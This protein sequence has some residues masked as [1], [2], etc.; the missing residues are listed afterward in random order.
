MS[1]LNLFRASRRTLAGAHVSTLAAHAQLQ[2]QQR[3]AQHQQYGGEHRRVGIA[4]LQLELLID[5]RGEGLQADDRQGA[6]LHQHVQGNQQRTRQ[7]RRPEQGQGDLEKY[8]P[9]IL[10]QRA[11]G[12]FE[13]WVKVAQRC[14]YGQENQRVFGQAHHQDSPA[15]S[16]EMS[17]EGNPGEA[18][19]KCRNGERQA[20]DYA[21][22]STARQIA[23]LQ[24]PGE[25]QSDYPAYHGDANHQCECVAQQAE[26]IRSP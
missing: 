23:A 6:E 22:Q 17:A 18:A 24:Q 15:K 7:Q 1:Q 20:E 9:T 14:R 3:Q 4:E 13:G 12:L 21:P 11:R 5:R 10:P 2:P 16:L 19:D 26:H 8:A 25:R